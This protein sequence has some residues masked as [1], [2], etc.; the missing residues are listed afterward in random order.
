MLNLKEMST[1]FKVST[2]TICAKLPD[3]RIHLLNVGKYLEIDDQILGI[4]Y[5]HANLNILKGQYRT[6]V[7]KKAKNKDVG[8]VNVELFY[9]QISIIV[10]IDRE[11]GGGVNAKLFANGSLHLTGCKHVD[12]ACAV[13][14]ILYNKLQGLKGRTTKLLLHKDID[15]ILL[16][17]DNLIYS[18]NNHTVIGHKDT[19][20]DHYV[21]NKKQYTIDSRTGMFI[22]L[23][24]ENKKKR[25]ICNLDGVPMGYTQIQLVRNNTKLYK[26]NGNLHYDFVNG[27]IYCN[28]SVIIGKIEHNIDDNLITDAT[29]YE[30][31]FEIDYK[32]QPFGGAEYHLDIQSKD[33]VT[34][35][36]VNVHCI[37][38]CFSLNSKINRLKL[39]ECLIDEGYITKYNPESY[40]GIKVVYKLQ[41]F[42]G[43]QKASASG[44]CYCSVKCICTNITFLIFQSGNVIATG[45]KGMHQVPVCI[46]SFLSAIDGHMDHVKQHTQTPKHDS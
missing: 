27:L 34:L 16:D 28:N 42:D 15:D 29:L 46:Q 14:K 43:S 24:E 20:H 9:N 45:F 19:L 36:D 33:F 2:M 44:K 13:V 25:T 39:Y 6:T 10:N 32:I 18:Y 5:S 8:K 41:D 11:G 7:F 37:N 38:V 22:A 23:K 12:D 1:P 31:A 4:K 21:L 40:S 30:D 17:K 35:I 26:K 3:C